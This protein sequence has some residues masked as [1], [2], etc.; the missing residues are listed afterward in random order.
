MTLDEIVKQIHPKQ[1]KVT[2]ENEWFEVTISEE[3]ATV[4]KQA[5]TFERA[6]DCAFRAWVEA[7]RG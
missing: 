6:I 1:I 5:M 4:V 7:H 2:F 3:T